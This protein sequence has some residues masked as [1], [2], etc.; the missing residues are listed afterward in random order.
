VRDLF[1][2]DIRAASVLTLYLLPEV[3]LQLRPRLLAQ[4]QPG[5]RVVSHDWDMGDW[6]PDAWAGVT[7]LDKPVMPMRSSMVYLWIIPA[8]VAGAWK[9]SVDGMDEAL[10]IEFAQRFQEISGAAARGRGRA[11]LQ[12]ARLRGMEIGFAVV[13]EGIGLSAPLQ[14]FGRVH[15]DTMDGTTGSGGRWRAERRPG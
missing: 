4:L 13:G 5:T 9:V 8:Q 1:E 12:S 2:T 14:F 10:D 11:A 15:G 3:N 6:R 7:D